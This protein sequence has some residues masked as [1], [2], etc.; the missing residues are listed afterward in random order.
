MIF[1]EG[2]ECPIFKMCS[3]YTEKPKKKTSHSPTYQV[4]TKTPGKNVVVN[5]KT[6]KTAW[7]CDKKIT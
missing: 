6:N 1:C 2:L 3:R 7:I 5:E 4:F